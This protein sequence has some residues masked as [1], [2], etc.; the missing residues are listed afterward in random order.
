MCT[1]SCE[2]EEGI[3]LFDQ[4]DMVEALQ[5][6]ETDEATALIEFLESQIR[7]TVAIPQD[8]QFFSNPILKLLDQGKGSVHCEAYR[9][10]YQSED[11]D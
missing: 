2:T 11:C 7:G 5:S 9:N 6:L 1:V 8:N 4:E 3:F 10:G